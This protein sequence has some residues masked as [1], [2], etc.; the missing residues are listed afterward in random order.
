MTKL[1]IV[2]FA[3]LLLPIASVYASFATLFPKGELFHSCR[4]S[5]THSHDSLNIIL[6]HGC[7]NMQLSSLNTF[8]L[9]RIKSRAGLNTKVSCQNIKNTNGQ[10]FIC[11][12]KNEA[13]PQALS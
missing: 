7:K 1:K 2:L 8:V 9:T 3:L 12:Y 6:F 10:D 13:K 5:E 11:S 4:I